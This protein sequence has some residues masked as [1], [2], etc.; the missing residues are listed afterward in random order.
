M[1]VVSTR[2]AL[3]LVALLVLP[4]LL[5]LRHVY[6]RIPA[7]DCLNPKLMLRTELIP[8]SVGVEEQRKKYGVNRIQ[9]SEGRVPV[10][11]PGAIPI[12]LSKHE[13]E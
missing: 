9:W 10:D 7:D 3:P 11:F 1:I 2:Y 6:F 13:R 8:G 4:T 12:T 5:G